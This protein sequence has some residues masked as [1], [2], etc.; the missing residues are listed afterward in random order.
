MAYYKIAGI[1]SFVAALHF[2]GG[3]GFAV[4]GLLKHE[5]L[6]GNKEGSE[7]P[8]RG[9]QYKKFGLV[10]VLTSDE[11]KTLPKSNDMTYSIIGCG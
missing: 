6:N 5:E 11:P 9:H 2:A 1:V 10:P 3:E 8:I 7:D 4:D